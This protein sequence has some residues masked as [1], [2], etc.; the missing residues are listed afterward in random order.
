MSVRF[1]AGTDG[2]S[3]TANVPNYNG[4]YTAMGWFWLASDRNDAC[5]LFYLGT[6]DI[7]AYDY[8]YTDVDGVTFSVSA[9]GNV[10]HGT[11]LALTTWYHLALVRES[12]SS[13]KGYLNGVVDCSQATNVGTSRTAVERLDA[14]ALV[15]LPGIQPL[16]GRVAGIKVWDTALTLAEIQ[17]EM[18]TLRPQRY[19][20]LNLWSPCF[21]GSG[22]RTRDYSGNGRTWTEA[23]TLTD[24]DPP[25]VS[26]GAPT[27]WVPYAAPVTAQLARPRADVSTGG[28][29][30]VG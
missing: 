13:L 10:A 1:D 28:W 20:N 5:T 29:Q 25:P 9:S 18:H 27:L 22:E 16:D 15:S 6:N 24:E 2:L 17:Q 7:L 12:A 3:R 4:T 30:R 21:P 14:G 11:A 23:G 8:L 19:A 26:Y